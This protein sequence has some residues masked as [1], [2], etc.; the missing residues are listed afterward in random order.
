MPKTLSYDPCNVICMRS[1]PKFED[2][3]PGSRKDTKLESVTSLEINRESGGSGIIRLQAFY[4]YSGTR[5]HGKTKH[6]EFM[7]GAELRLRDTDQLGMG[8][9]SHQ[10]EEAS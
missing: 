1:L 7:S 8:S 2:R 5:W 9:E 6:G 4:H 3:P 10:Y